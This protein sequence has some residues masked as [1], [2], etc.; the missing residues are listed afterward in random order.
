MHK[1]ADRRLPPRK[2]NSS[3]APSGHS[4][5]A[6]ASL[7]AVRSR[8]MLLLKSSSAD[9]TVACRSTR[10]SGRRLGDC[11][12]RFRTSSVENSRSE[13]ESV[14]FLSLSNPA[15]ELALTGSVRLF[16]CAHG[17]PTRGFLWTLVIGGAQ[18]WQTTGRPVSSTP[19]MPPSS[20]GSPHRRAPTAA[21]PTARSSS[22]SAS[23]GPASGQ[24]ATCQA[25]R[26]WRSFLLGRA[27]L[28]LPERAE[29]GGVFPWCLRPRATA[30]AMRSGTQRGA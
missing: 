29:K 25:D 21:S 2:Q 27:S 16:F 6:R 28:A 14:C 23:R 26:S 22:R 3:G 11:R 19:Q 17:A 24:G 20:H 12:V 7:S 13:R 10:Q 8:A 4:R 18:P 1:R 30:R 5:L 9:D 15:A